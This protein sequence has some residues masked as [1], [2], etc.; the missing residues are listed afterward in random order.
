MGENPAKGVRLPE[1]QRR[2]AHALTFEQ[3]KAV[4][5][6]L[7]SPVAE[8]TLVS[9]TCS[10]N[11]AELLGLRWKWVNLTGTPVVVDT[12]VLHPYTLAVRQNYYRGHFG[13][14]KAKSRRRNVPLSTSLVEALTRLR[15]KS[16][17]AAAEDL[18]FASKNGTPLTERNLTRRYLKPAGKKLGMPWLSWHV[19]RHTHA[20]FGEQ[21]GM[22]LSDRQAQMGNA[23]V[24]MTLHYTHSDLERRSAAVETIAQK[25]VG[26]QNGA[27]N[28]ANLT[29]NDTNAERKEAV[30]Y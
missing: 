28:K 15:Q 22:A 30:S 6:A 19:F 14:R 13:S 12:E 10:L 24:E 1:M 23:D 4:L 27:K 16:S 9:M 21:I 11:V 2:Q 26:G 3:G 20:T 7:P 8:M 5:A 25:L 17:F 18:V 29:L